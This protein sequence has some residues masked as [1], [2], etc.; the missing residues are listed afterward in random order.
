M[1]NRI[2]LTAIFLVMILS[3]TA[4]SALYDRGGGGSRTLIILTIILNSYKST[5]IEIPSQNFNII[6]TL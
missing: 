2:L 5:N 6:G 3:S 1:K 4:Q